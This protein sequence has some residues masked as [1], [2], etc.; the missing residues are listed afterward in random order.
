MEYVILGMLCFSRIDIIPACVPFEKDPI[1][2]YISKEK[3]QKEADRLNIELKEAFEKDGFTV[4][5]IE[6]KC[7]E[8]KT[9]KTTA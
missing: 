6:T 4:H 9:N 1:V 8:E 5:S 7:V 3:C 2:H